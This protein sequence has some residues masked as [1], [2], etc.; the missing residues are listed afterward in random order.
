MVMSSRAACDAV[1]GG[2]TWL[3]AGL[4]EMLGEVGW[5]GVQGDV[6]RCSA[7]RYCVLSL[8]LLLL[9]PPPPPPLLLVLLLL[10]FVLC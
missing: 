8:W 7:V 9:A 3:R 10:I 2:G 4:G 5:R 1:R 6:V